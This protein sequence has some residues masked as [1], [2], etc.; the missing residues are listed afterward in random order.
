MKRTAFTSSWLLSWLLSACAVP[1]II[2]MP[3]PA[4]LPVE[5]GGYSQEFWEGTS[6]PKVSGEYHKVPSIY[7]VGEDNG[8]FLDGSDISF[9]SLFAFE[10]ADRSSRPGELP[11]D[12][13]EFFLIQQMS[14]DRFLLE[15]FAPVMGEIV[16]HNFES[17]EGDF[18]CVNGF[19]Q[20]PVSGHYGSIEGMSVNGQY[21]KKFRI[22][23][24]GDLVSILSSGPYRSRRSAD[25]L[26]FVHEFHLFKRM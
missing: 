1:P 18:E 2:S 24:S 15:H 8:R 6:C 22:S 4:N 3:E 19:I 16:R 17:A 10:L 26:D 21:V 12:K 20:F 9:Y 7:E 11:R 14:A 23:E 5:W 13:P 25:R